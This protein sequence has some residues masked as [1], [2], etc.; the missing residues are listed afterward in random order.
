MHLAFYS[1]RCWTAA[2]TDRNQRNDALKN[3]LA[4]GLAVFFWD[5]AIFGHLISHH[6][7]LR[8]ASCSARLA[9]FSS[10]QPDFSLV[11]RMLCG[12]KHSFVFCISRAA[13]P[14]GCW[15]SG[16]TL[17]VF[18][19]VDN[20]MAHTLRLS[21]TSTCCRVYMQQNSMCAYITCCFFRGQIYLPCR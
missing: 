16:K 11:L 1:K 17:S 4:R 8:S 21:I 18:V 7:F 5:T 15:R 14:R 10:S 3:C 9:L 13:F 6:S 20:V 2:M 12:I 19:C